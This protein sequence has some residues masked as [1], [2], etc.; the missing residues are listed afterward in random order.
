MLASFPAYFTKSLG[1]TQ[2]IPCVFCFICRKICLRNPHTPIVRY[3]LR[4]TI[5]PSHCKFALFLGVAQKNGIIGNRRVREVK[6]PQP[7]FSSFIQ[8]HVAADL[9]AAFFMPYHGRRF[10]S[11]HHEVPGSDFA[12]ASAPGQPVPRDPTTITEFDE[13]LVKRLISKITVFEDHFTI[14]FKSG[15]T[16]D[17]EA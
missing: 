15:V 11:A 5:F 6:N 12:G 8:V 17:I 16:I 2:S 10:P 13:T 14:D 7:G 4:G 9:T 1:N 3:C